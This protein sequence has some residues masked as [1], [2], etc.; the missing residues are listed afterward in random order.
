ME[1]LLVSRLLLTVNLL[2]IWLVVFHHI[3]DT[4]DFTSSVFFLSA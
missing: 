2:S 1:F 4:L 3:G